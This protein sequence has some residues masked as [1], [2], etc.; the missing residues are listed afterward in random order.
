MFENGLFVFHRDYR[1]ADNTALNEALSNCK[2]V[3][4]S[5]IFTPDQVGKQNDYRS[6][7]S[8]QFMIESLE[9]LQRE[10]E[11]KHGRFIICYGEHVRMIDMLIKK[12]DIDA[13]YCNKDYTPYA[14]ERQTIT[15]ELCQKYNIPFFSCSGDYYL[16][17]PGA[18]V[19][20]QS[21]G[22]KKYTPFYNE[23]V[24]RMVR[25]PSYKRNI[26][27]ASTSITIPHT[28]SLSDAKQRFIGRENNDILVHGGRQEGLSRL[29]IAA[30]TQK[31][32]EENRDKFTY[33]TTFLSAYIKFGCI[34]I[35]EVYYTFSKA[36]GKDS[37]IIRELIW[38]DFFAHVLFHYPQVLNQSYQQR[39][40]GLKWRSSIEDFEK[41][42]S[43]NTGFP[44]VDAGM[45]QLNKTGYM[46][47]RVR[48]I[49]ASFLIKVLLL[50]WRWGEKYFAQKLTDYDIASNNGN[51]QGI[52]GTGVDMK[53]YFRDMNPWIQSAK[54]DKDTE[55]IKY[56][57]PELSQVSPR[58]IHLWHEKHDKYSNIGYP[59]PMVDYYEQKK[60]MLHMYA[61]V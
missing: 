1:L 24:N 23:V 36:F 21:S 41:W 11:S 29:K 56:W 53:P 51:W 10:V 49:V 35:R 47:N 30:K 31:K 7:N 12:L 34:S 4:C 61:S 16:H 37:G 17:E 22:F 55:Y 8:I 2:N 39:Y 20:G 52:S 59:K 57:V 50:D 43:G 38:R 60:K 3:F 25:S 48:M 33:N 13:V 28:I 14:L 15:D 40:R 32:Y 19:T 6:N 18:I 26:H 42:K 44:V 54:F 46:H 5:F 58:D 45:R 27:I 9:D